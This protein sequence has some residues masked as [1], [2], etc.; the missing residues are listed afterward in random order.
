M[1]SSDLNPDKTADDIQR[2]LQ[3]I[4]DT[5]KFALTDP[6]KEILQGFIDKDKPIIIFKKPVVEGAFD[7]TCAQEYLKT[8][9]NLGVINKLQ[10]NLSISSATRLAILEMYTYLLRSI[11][12]EIDN[13]MNSLSIQLQS[14]IVSSQQSKDP[15]ALQ[16]AV[17]DFQKISAKF[18]NRE[19]L[20]NQQLLD[21]ASQCMQFNV[22][23]NTEL[24][25]LNSKTMLL[26]TEIFDFLEQFVEHDA[27]VKLGIQA[28]ITG[29][30][31]NCMRDANSAIQ[32]IEQQITEER[33]TT[34][35]FN[36]QREKDARIAAEAET[37]RLAA[38][39]RKKEEAR[40]AE[41]A[42][43]AQAGMLALRMHQ[44]AEKQRQ[45]KAQAAARRT[46]EEATARRAQEES[47]AMWNRIYQASST[48]RKPW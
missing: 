29:Y 28:A 8:I 43:R 47:K 1:C 48:Q 14:S 16:A 27:I 38:E 41:E 37:A 23:H 44:E 21:I 36:L 3:S 34:L 30:L 18:D 20:S 10:V 6:Q 33:I 17:K 19:V 42:K 22:N 26:K 46:Q 9:E 15:K 32:T 31:S 45:H 25:T 4:I 39:V 35:Q 12:L 13:L 2:T 5:P 40:L 24:L 11:N 7:T